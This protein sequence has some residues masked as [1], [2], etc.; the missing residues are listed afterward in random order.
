M[1]TPDEKKELAALRAIAA[2][3]E[4]APPNSGGLSPEEVLELQELRALSGQDVGE[5]VDKSDNFAYAFKK[6]GNFTRDAGDYLETIVPLGNVVMPWADDFEETGFYL[7]PTDMYGKEWD[8]ADQ[9]RR[10]EL[11]QEYRAKNIE[12]E[13]GGF[14]PNEDH[15][16]Y[17]AGSVTKAIADPLTAVPFGRGLKV[18][19]GVGAAVGGLSS[20]ASDLARDGE[21]DPYDIA[22]DAALSG[23]FSGAFQAVGSKTVNVVRK[24]GA[25]KRVAKAQKVL[26][27]SGSKDVT[28]ALEDAGYTNKE[29]AEVGSSAKLVGKKL[30]VRKANIN[31]PEA[32]IQSELVR[33][34]A[35]RPDSK[36]DKVLGA[37]STRIANIHPAL[38]RRVRQYEQNSKQRYIDY[39]TEAKPFVLAFRELADE[40]RKQVGFLLS[41]S[42]FDEVA[43]IFG[44][45]SP[46]GQ[47]LPQVKNL[48]NRI[49]E[50]LRSSG[51]KFESEVNYFPRLVKDY[52]KM[53]DE[54]FGTNINN[55]ISRKIVELGKKK[56]GLDKVTMNEKDKIANQVLRNYDP[57]IA[58]G[59]PS[60]LK[61]RVVKTID[62]D[63]HANYYASADEALIKYLSGASH[64]IEM[65]KFFGR[66]GTENL[67]ESIGALARSFNISSQQVD[68]LSSML[69]ARFTGGRQSANKWNQA[70][71]DIG[72]MGTIGQ[73]TSTATQ[74]GDIGIAG[75][76]HGWKNT[77][78]SLFGA[79]GNKSKIK[80]IDIALDD[81]IMT[82][83]ASNPTLTSNL[84]NKVLTATGFRAMDRLGKETIINSSF[85]ML[86]KQANK[87]PDVIRKKWGKYYGDDMDALIDDLAAG[88]VTPLTK[89]H[90]FATLSDFQP[91]SMS[92]LPEEYAKNPNARML[93]MLKSFTL[94]MWDVARKNVYNEWRNGS[95]IQ[96]AQTAGILAL[97]LSATNYAV[98]KVKDLMRGRDVSMKPEDLP[99]DLMWTLLGVFGFGKYQAEQLGSQGLVRTVA[100]IVVPPVPVADIAEAVYD[101]AT[102]D[103]FS[104]DS[105]LDPD[106]NT[107]RVMKKVPYAGEVAAEWFLGGAEAYNAK[108]QAEEISK[109]TDIDM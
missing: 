103:E 43:K 36:L 81:E 31:S 98:G 82:E 24:R 30:V 99:S 60:N 85:K 62:S 58:S 79:I 96:A 50:D 14:K 35:T 15:W 89:E 47:S 42:K 68:D 59:T 104:S 49:G 16:S 53:S 21:L 4:T 27:D 10:L 51:R 71:K 9:G 32:E 88:K 6:E 67:E 3:T 91:I 19:V 11:I 87:K 61:Q 74:A 8:E 70:A 86:Q 95:K 107:R 94:K 102:E 73:F 48:I 38:S 5:D 39:N 108:K 44:A 92:E 33:N 29:I 80:L 93:Y 106:K 22:K 69:T 40:E 20:A 65:N 101:M 83:L 105:L 84:L 78:A 56:G 54:M 90:A 109:L 17:A 37:M 57:I 1:L 72:Y 77:I 45:D 64:D 76:M 46:I 34:A 2:G 100:G 26:D 52:N 7:S 41:N 25:K 97:N 23:L 18:A 55:V 75:A 13:F 66:F 28:K 12:A 63:V